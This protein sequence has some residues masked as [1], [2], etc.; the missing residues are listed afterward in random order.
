MSNNNDKVNL[1]DSGEQDQNIKVYDNEAY[2]FGD[3]NSNDQSV[4]GDD[5]ALQEN[6]LHSN[7]NSNEN[8]SDEE[9]GNQPYYH[10]EFPNPNGVHEEEQHQGNT[11][12]N[13]EEEEEENHEEGE[14][15]S[16][17]ENEEEG[18][19]LITLKYISICQCC[20]NSF[21][22]TLIWLYAKYLASGYFCTE[23]QTN[24][25]MIII[26][27]KRFSKKESV[28]LKAI[29]GISFNLDK[30]IIFIKNKKNH[31]FL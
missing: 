11:I 14:Q 8:N 10:P 12:R 27:P 24:E 17:E 13:K 6:E 1:D 22:R 23:A 31:Q 16:G 29:D 4:P 21:N 15:E 30:K 25:P 26:K 19:P 28:K 9:E 7:K 3:D 2:M 18:I 20:K 5:V